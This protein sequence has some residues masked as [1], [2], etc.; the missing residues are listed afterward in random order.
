MIF[1]GRLLASL[2]RR[3]RG[4]ALGLERASFPTRAHGALELLPRVPGFPRAHEVR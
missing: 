2:R 1:A 4:A 3:S